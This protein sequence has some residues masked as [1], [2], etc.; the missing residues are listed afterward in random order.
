MKNKE[1]ITALIF[2][3]F[4]VVIKIGLNLSVVVSTTMAGIIAGIGYYLMSKENITF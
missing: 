2:V 3:L 4:L 1:C